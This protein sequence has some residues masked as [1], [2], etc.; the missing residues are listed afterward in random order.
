LQRW[1]TRLSL[2]DTGLCVGALRLRR[3]HRLLLG[4]ELSRQGSLLSGQGLEGR[5]ESR[6]FLLQKRHGLVSFRYGRPGS[7]VLAWTATR[8]GGCLVMVAICA[9]FFPH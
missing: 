2:R 9:E 3:C 5:L 1:N 6:G 8:N 7:Q 4:G